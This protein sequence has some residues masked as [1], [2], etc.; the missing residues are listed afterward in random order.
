MENDFQ[1]LLNKI[2][3]LEKRISKLENQDENLFWVDEVSNLVWEL[4][5]NPDE[6][7]TFFQAEKYVENLN[8]QKYGG[9]SDWNIPTKL[10]L[11]TLFDLS[12]EP[13]LKS[14]LSQNIPSKFR[15]VFWSSTKEKNLKW[16]AF[17]NFGYGDFRYKTHRYYFM[18]V[19]K[20]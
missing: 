18:A 20:F 8:N 10:E 17:F 11:E 1:K 15:P 19:H 6:L 12:Q 2:S 3:E 9:Y 5:Q 7:L 16:V 4:Q 14:E 13:H